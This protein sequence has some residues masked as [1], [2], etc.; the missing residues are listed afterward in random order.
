MELRSK[1]FRLCAIALLFGILSS[2]VLAQDT[3]PEAQTDMVL[4]T[5][6]PYEADSA[7]SPISSALQMI[8]ALGCVIALAYLI[9][10][11]GLGSILGRQRNGELI[12]IKER[13]SLDGKNALFLVEFNG[14]QIL[15]STSERGV[16]LVMPPINPEM[17]AVSK[18]VSFA[19]LQKN[20]REDA[21]PAC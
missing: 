4:E 12:K 10:H 20:L 13:I 8:V 19:A 15:L 16:E 5:E 17:Q 18:Q 14:Q 1:S 6:A 21:R 7:F 9:L 11:K 3:K 2:S